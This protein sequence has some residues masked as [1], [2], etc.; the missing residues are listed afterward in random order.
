VL[1]AVLGY[2]LIRLA[3]DGFLA[4]AQLIGPFRVSQVIALWAALLA[5]WV[6]ARTHSVYALPAQQARE[7]SG[8]GAEADRKDQARMSLQDAPTG[9]CLH[10]PQSHALVPA[11]AKGPAA[12]SR[13]RNAQHPVKMPRICAYVFTGIEI[14]EPQ[15]TIEASGDCALPIGEH[16]Q[17]DDLAVM[18]V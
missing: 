8:R 15:L 3:A 13:Y 6:L 5:I 4:E 14:P 12:V 1:L 11:S 16:R 17:S 2:S 9:A 10:I 18:S 7:P